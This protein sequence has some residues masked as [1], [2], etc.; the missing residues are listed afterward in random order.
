[1]SN[2]IF[3]IVIWGILYVLHILLILLILFFE[4]KKEKQLILEESFAFH[5]GLLVIVISG[6][7][8]ILGFPKVGAYVLYS[9]ILFGLYNFLGVIIDSYI[10]KKN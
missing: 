9:G 3:S 4:K 8:F 1:M 6:G 5:V 10:S 7:A 2:T